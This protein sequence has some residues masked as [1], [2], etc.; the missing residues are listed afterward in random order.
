MAPSADATT[1]RRGRVRVAITGMGIKAPAGLNLDD[2]WTRLAS[3]A[4]CGAP[5]RRWDASP[6]PVGIGCEVPEFD[7]SAYLAP[8][9]ARRLDRVAQLGFAAAA[10]ALADAGELGADPARC[11]VVAGVGIGGLQTLEDQSQTLVAKGPLRVSPFTV[12]MMM[13]N[14]TP[15]L[16]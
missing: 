5:I 16:V 9:E 8:K 13:A 1:D 10:D 2:Y 3:G 14:A 15:A 11:A 4:S 12:P 7:I 6:M